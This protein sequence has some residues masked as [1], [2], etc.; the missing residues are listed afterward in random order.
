MTFEG[1]SLDIIGGNAVFTSY[2]TNHVLLTHCLKSVKD[3]SAQAALVQDLKLKKW[4]TSEMENTI[5]DFFERM[6]NRF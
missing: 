1:A 2:I 5:N 6:N 4:F 3:R